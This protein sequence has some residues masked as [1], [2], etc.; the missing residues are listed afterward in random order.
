MGQYAMQNG[1]L[2]SQGRLVI[3]PATAQPLIL[4]ILQQY[5]DS[6]LAGHY[7]VA[8]THALVAQYFVWPG[9]ASRG[10][11]GMWRHMSEATTP[12]LGIRSSGMCL[13]GSS[14]LSLSITAL[15][16]VAA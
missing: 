4:Q 5:H 1:L 15:K 12:A 16:E 9:L 14:L 3:P 8:R 10:W 13:M 6:T 7:G 11:P 2:Y